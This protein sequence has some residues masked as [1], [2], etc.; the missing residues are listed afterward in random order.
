MRSRLEDY[1]LSGYA[2]TYWG[3]YAQGMT[4]ST[5]QEDV[6]KTFRLDGKREAMYQIKM[7]VKADNFI[8]PDMGLSLLH[9]LA[10]NGLVAIISGNFYDD[11]LYVPSVL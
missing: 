8:A 6:L 4:E 10:E 3:R 5:V 9:I 11:N 2:A 7:Y 1:K